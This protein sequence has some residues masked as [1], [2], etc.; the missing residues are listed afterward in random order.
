[1]LS[2]QK[3][4]DVLLKPRKFSLPKD[5]SSFSEGTWGEVSHPISQPSLTS[6]I[7]TCVVTQ[8][9]SITSNDDMGPT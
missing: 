6:P 2:V 8:P 5:P 7:G 1:M 4:S 3:I 9:L